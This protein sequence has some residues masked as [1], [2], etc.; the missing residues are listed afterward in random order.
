M[1]KIMR[2]V[3][4]WTLIT[5]SAIASAAVLAR[6]GESSGEV[7]HVL[8]ERG[9]VP[10]G[11]DAT[12]TNYD[13]WIPPGCAMDGTIPKEWTG[14]RFSLSANLGC[15]DALYDG[16]TNPFAQPPSGAPRSPGSKQT[17]PSGGTRIDWTN[18]AAPVT[19]GDPAIRD[20]HFGYQFDH[21]NSGCP[22]GSTNGP[23]AT[24]GRFGGE[25][26]EWCPA[27]TT[28]IV[29]TQVSPLDSTSSSD[30]KSQ[31]WGARVDVW[32]ESTEAISV[33]LGAIPWP[34]GPPRDTGMDLLERLVAEDS[35]FGA[36]FDAISLA[37]DTVPPGESLGFE[38]DVPD[39]ETVVLARYSVAS[40]RGELEYVAYIAFESK[41]V[42]L[43]PLDPTQTDTPEAT[44]PATDTPPIPGT[45]TPTPTP[46][47][48]QI[49]LPVCYKAGAIAV[50]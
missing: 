7:Q 38:F 15:I 44:S 18:A 36:P 3:F 46:D 9:L 50:P 16:P 11:V 40:I 45:T 14:F 8:A 39:D 41:V 49:Y 27:T 28:K 42:P 2:S 47:P 22:S 32:N 26:M 6:Q 21:S 13:A 12:Y 48:W 10:M 25:T 30:S 24:W 1:I 19:A 17:S 34:E 35:L 23:I 37:D 5:G 29:F 4:L 31:I 33:T 20:G 43:F